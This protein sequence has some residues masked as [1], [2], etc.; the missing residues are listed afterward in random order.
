MN[1][2]QIARTASLMGEP[3]RTAML[4][5]LMDGRALTARELSLVA[6]V[7]PATASRHLALLLDAGFLVVA[8]QGRHRYYR[9][10]SP[11]VASLIETLMQVSMPAISPVKTG[12]R[13]QALRTARI[14][15]DHLAGR[16]GLA[17]AD[18]LVASSALVLQDNAHVLPGDRLNKTLQRLGVSEGAQALAGRSSR[19]VCL[20]C[21]DWSERRSHVA[22]RL[23]ALI[24]SHCL[25][26]G[27]LLRRPGTRALQ[28]SEPGARSLRDW[29][30]T[31]RW[32]EVTDA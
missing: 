18:H 23:G 26:Q 20:P 32:R 6:G 1:T 22:G 8:K 4:L 16:L 17:V 31:A 15:Y 29:M 5:A 2:N 10:A 11:D 7:S 13:D 12:P 24:C 21:L 25:T 19:P 27:W 14:C 3:A 30:G 9:L 28:V